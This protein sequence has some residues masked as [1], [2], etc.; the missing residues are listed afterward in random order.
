M[1]SLAAANPGAGIGTAATVPAI[2]GMDWFSG[3]LGDSWP[4]TMNASTPTV[5]PAAS[6]NVNNSTSLPRVSPAPSADTG[7][8]AAAAQ[9]TSEAVAP[10]PADDIKPSGLKQMSWGDDLE[11]KLS[12]ADL[13]KITKEQMQWG[14]SDEKA[15]Q[16]AK[17]DKEMAQAKKSFNEMTPKQQESVMKLLKDKP[18]A[19]PSSKAKS[20]DN[21]VR[22]MLNGTID[23]KT[24]EKM[25]PAQKRAYQNKWLDF[26]GSDF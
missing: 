24:L 25:T 4:G 15:L 6:M 14:A 18:E 1:A 7:V 19:K 12:Q 17:I 2:S 23:K 3:R 21:K 10:L 13:S 16:F 8:N 11:P 26:Y 9:M 20:F 22:T 5:K